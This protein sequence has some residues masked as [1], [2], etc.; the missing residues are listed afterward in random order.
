ML[1]HPHEEDQTCQICLMPLFDDYNVNLH[2]ISASNDVYHSECLSQYVRSQIDQ[3]KLPITS[4]NPSCKVPLSIEIDL[5]KL[6]R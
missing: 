2:T 6:L 5:K 3:G 4:P 1:A